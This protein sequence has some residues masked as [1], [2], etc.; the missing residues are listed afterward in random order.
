MLVDRR[1]EMREQRIRAKVLYQ[2]LA[3]GNTAEAEKL[4]AG[5]VDDMRAAY[6]ATQLVENEER[7]M[8]QR[9][10]SKEESLQARAIAAISGGLPLRSWTSAP[11]W[12]S[13]VSSS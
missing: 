5:I 8:R 7:M 6:E 9:T 12:P 1:E 3:A 13:A 4:Y 2:A 11:G 10:T